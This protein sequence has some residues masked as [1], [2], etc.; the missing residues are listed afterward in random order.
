MDGGQHLYFSVVVD[1]FF[2]F[3]R[4]RSDVRAISKVVAIC[5]GDAKIRNSRFVRSTGWNANILGT[6]Y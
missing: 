1:V 2:F 5:F 3:N 4:G 6:P